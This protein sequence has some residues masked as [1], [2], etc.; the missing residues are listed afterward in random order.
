MHVFTYQMQHM[1][2]HICD[3]GQGWSDNMPK[4]DVLRLIISQAHAHRQ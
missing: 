2:V 4:W 3:V 1:R